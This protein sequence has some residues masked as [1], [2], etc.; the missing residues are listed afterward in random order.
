MRHDGSVAANQNSESYSK[1][2]LRGRIRAL[3]AER[4]AIQRQESGE[5]IAAHVMGIVAE[6]RSSSVACYFSIANEPTT[7]PLMEQ[8]W[9]AGIEVLTPRVRATELEWVR[10]TP[11]SEYT[12][13]SF[14]IREVA[15]GEVLPLAKVDLVF[16]PA[17]AVSATGARL[18]Q[19]GGFYDRAVARLEEIPLLIAV[20]Y[21]DED[22]IDVPTEAHDVPVD[23][24]ATEQGV[25]WTTTGA[26]SQSR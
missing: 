2:E 19:G 4:S 7:E 10:S 20:L 13:G 14:G 8:L 12:S 6:R 25:R 9:A 23:A 21:A 3:R 18:G 17:L 11:T 15:G 5:S 16:L 1:S 24:V 26:S 22:G